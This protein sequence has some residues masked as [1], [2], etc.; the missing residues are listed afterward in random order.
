MCIYVGIYIYILYI[1]PMIQ[2]KNNWC[3]VKQMSITDV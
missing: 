1:T 2:S 3:I